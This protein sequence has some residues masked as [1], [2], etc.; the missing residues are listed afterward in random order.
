MRAA[1]HRADRPGGGEPL[2][3]SSETV[4]KPGRT[5]EEAIEN[6]DIGGPSMLRSAAKN[7][8]RVTVLVDPDDYA[9]VLAE[10]RA[11]GGEVSAATNR[12]LAQKVFHTTALYD[13][14]I[15]DYLGAACGVAASA[16]RSTGAA[17][18]AHDLRYGENPHQQAALYGDFLRVAEPLHGKELSY[19]NIVDINAA[20]ALMREF[21]ADP[22]RRSRSS[23]TTRRA[24]S[25]LGRDP[26]EAWQRAYA[27]DPESPFG[28]I[29]IA[30]RPWTL[31]LAAG[32]G[33]D[34][35][36]GADRAGV[37][38]RRARAAAKKK[39]RRLMRWHR[40]RRMPADAAGAA[41]RRRRPA[42]AGR[43]PRDARI[44][45]QAHGRDEARA[46]P[47]TSSRALD[48]AWR[49]VKH[50]KSN[51]IVFATA[52]PHA[53]ASAAARRRASS[54]CARR[55]RPRAAPRHLAGRLGA[56]RATRSSPSPTASR[57]RIAAGATAVVQPGGS[58]RDDEV[59]GAA[60]A[61][62]I[63]MVFTGV[64]HFRH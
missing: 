60:D 36:R 4:A 23:S 55:A 50:V 58:V 6:I 25:A 10:L 40:R 33:R 30:T 62:G 1:R 17:T 59:I 8:A 52:G 34:L 45:R 27:T 22:T 49:V 48:F 46:R 16:R 2:S 63:A 57:R 31:A 29:V 26:L 24:A 41:Q 61:H 35:H 12:R 39:N 19:N 14:A 5:L 51:A 13:G 11:T 21:R 37:R 44:A 28:G 32:R 54:R 64:R 38:A 9:A 43:R 7:H 18:K 53:R 47:P 56:R 3:R 42:R 15:A 20:L